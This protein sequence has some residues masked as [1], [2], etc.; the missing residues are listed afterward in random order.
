MPIYKIRG[1]DVDFPFQAYDCQI[2]YM[3]K[4][5]QSLQEVSPFFFSSSSLKKFL[6]LTP[7]NSILDSIAKCSLLLYRFHQH[8][9]VSR[10]TGPVLLN[11]LV[12]TSVYSM[13][14]R[15]GKFCEVFHLVCYGT[16]LVWQMG[17]CSRVFQFQPWSWNCVCKNVPS[18]SGTTC[19]YLGTLRNWWTKN[20]S[21]TMLITLYT[22][23]TWSNQ[24]NL[25]S[26][27]H[28]TK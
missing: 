24:V 23:K 11:Q 12:Y 5:I 26:N 2:V 25:W 16:Q 8:L 27:N 15:F 4:V 3:E 18:T 21:F 1:I 17:T 19:R 13:Y 14:W 20:L 6:V 7:A 28:T 9:F 22:A 10:T